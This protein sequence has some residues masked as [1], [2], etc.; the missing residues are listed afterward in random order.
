MVLAYDGAMTYEADAARLYQDERWGRA[1]GDTAVLELSAT[2]AKSVSY[3]DDLRL[4]HLEE[5][6]SMF[7]RR[8]REQPPKFV[9]FCGLGNDPIR[10]VPYLE[11]W[12]AIAQHD[13]MVDKPVKLGGTVFVV[14]KHPTAHGTTTEHWMDLA[15]RVRAM[16]GGG[17][18]S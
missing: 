10:D 1:D 6:I 13:L 12:R 15:R 7:R 8:L 4:S 11:Y 17:S 16:T 2:A 18:N 14:Q 5:R 3:V 9:V